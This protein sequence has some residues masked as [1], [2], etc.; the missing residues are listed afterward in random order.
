MTLLDFT[1]AKLQQL[2]EPL[3]QEVNDFID[4]VIYKYQ[5]RATDSQS[6]EEFVRAWTQWFETADHLDR[7]IL[8]EP[9][10]DYQQLLLDK[11]RQQG[12]DL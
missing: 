2:P 7:A 10:T 1:I 3:L 8:S 4:Y 9:V 12:L 6:A 5:A 11:Y